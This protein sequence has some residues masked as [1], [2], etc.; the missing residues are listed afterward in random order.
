MRP[1]WQMSNQR[2]RLVELKQGHSVGRGNSCLFPRMI[3]VPRSAFQE[4]RVGVKLR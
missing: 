1:I 4:L 3:L 2:L